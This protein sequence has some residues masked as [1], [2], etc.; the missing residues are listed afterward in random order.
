MR[1]IVESGIYLETLARLRRMKQA[2]EHVEARV[3]FALHRKIRRAPLSNEQ[4]GRFHRDGYL[5]VSGLI[6][7]PVAS[8]AASALWRFLDVSPHAPETWTVLGSHPYPLRDERVSAV[9]TDEMLAAAAQLAGDDVATFRR[10]RATCAFIRPVVPVWRSHPPHIDRTIAGLR[11][12]TFPRSYRIGALTYLTDVRPHGGGTIVFP[13]SHL[14]LEAIAKSD[15]IRYRYLWAL[16]I[17][18]SRI[19][20]G[21]PIELT[22]SCGDVLFHHHLCVHAATDNVGEVPRLALNQKW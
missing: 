4:I 15:P 22:P 7:S 20:L 11:Y 12:R 19:D 5:L 1:A 10:P 16:S 8:E 3:E 2:A 21:A 6:P 14:K 17:Q 13:G 9:Y 18:L